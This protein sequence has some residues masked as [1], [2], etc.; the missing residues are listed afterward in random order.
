MLPAVFK[1]RMK[2]LLGDDFEKFAA[3]YEKSAVKALRVNALHISRDEA[4][5]LLPFAATPVD[6]DGNALY[7]GADLPE[8]PGKEPLHHAGAFYIQEPSAMAPVACVDIKDGMSILDMCA[9]PG[10]KTVQ[11]AL[12]NAGG[13]IVSN[14]IVPSRAKTLVG[15]IERMGIKNAIVTN[16]D[17]K[18]LA[19]WFDGVFD[20]VICDAPCSGEG[21]FRK[22]PT[23]VSEWSV[24]NVVMCAKRQSEILENAARTVAAGGYLLYSTCT[25]SL[26]ENE[27][28]ID[29]FLSRHGE[30]ELC[31]VSEEVEKATS[32]GVCFEG[33]GREDIGKCRRFYPHISRGEGQFMAL[34]RKKEG[35]F[36]GVTYK[37]STL[38]LSK[39]EEETVRGFFKDNLTVTDFKLRKYRDNILI[40]PDFPVPPFAVFAA[41]VCVGSVEKGRLVPHHQLFSAFGKDFIRRAQLDRAQ[42]EKYLSGQTLNV[43]CENGWA[44]VLCCGV[45]L[46]GG[47]VVDSCLKNHYPKGLRNK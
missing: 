26:E 39:S 21:M 40:A 18:T 12:Q 20:L 17:S 19:D 13:V 27:M 11:A 34:M 1:S 46:G 5:R 2:E 15:N 9:S 33:C 23:A 36:A 25:F 42:S 28:Q 6:F 41:G 31:R 47:K 29:S 3:E 44:A 45:P 30:F 24:E 7:A 43:E 22:N 37:D 14:E 38:P 10:G 16:T 8:K 4:R 35:S 32:P